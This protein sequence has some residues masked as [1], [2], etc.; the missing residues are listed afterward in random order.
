MLC[1][2]VGILTDTTTTL[3]T[4]YTR[5][6]RGGVDVSSVRISELIDASANNAFSAGDTGN[7]IYTTGPRRL[8]SSWGEAVLDVSGT[9]TNVI[10]TVG[11]I[12]NP[13]VLGVFNGWLSSAELVLGNETTGVIP[14]TSMNSNQEE[15]G[16][17]H[18]FKNFYIIKLADTAFGTAGIPFSRIKNKTLTVNIFNKFLSNTRFG[19][20][21]TTTR[22]PTLYVTACGTTLQNI[23]NNFTTFSY[24]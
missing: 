3:P 12:S 2:H 18:E 16:L 21:S 8:S 10:G 19:V 1:L 22:R 7:G 15:F 5:F 14:V 23:T 24:I 13:D 20:L 4:H 6:N 9:S 11:Q 17:K